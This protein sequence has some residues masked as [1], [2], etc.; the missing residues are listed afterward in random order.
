MVAR[1]ALTAEIARPVQFLVDRLGE[2]ESIEACHDWMVEAVL[3]YGWKVLYFV[4]LSMPIRVETVRGLVTN[5]P[6]EWRRQ[7]VDADAHHGDPIVAQA[8]QSMLPVTWEVPDRATEADE[9]IG[10]VM[11]AARAAGLVRGA[12]FPVHGPVGRFAVL[13]VGTDQPRA[14]LERLVELHGP[15]LQYLALHLEAAVERCTVA[16]APDSNLTRRETECLHWSAQGKTSWE[17]AKI[18]EVAEVTVN[19]HLKNVMKKLSV[20]NRVHAVARAVALGLIAT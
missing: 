18:L 13:N 16:A 2:A 14:E 19:F 1:P 5:L 4:S 9:P 6:N 7:Y 11:A 10:A 15:E 17:T 12:S 3:G 8:A 20:S